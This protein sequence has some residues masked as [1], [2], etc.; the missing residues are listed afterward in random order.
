MLSATGSSEHFQLMDN[1]RLRYNV[2][3]N[4]LRRS[5]EETLHR[6]FCEERLRV[7]WFSED[8]TRRVIRQRQRQLSHLDTVIDGLDILIRQLLTAKNIWRTDHFVIA[9]L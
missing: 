8:R 3:M 4:M 1:F 7:Q 5:R 9:T 6:L 2:N